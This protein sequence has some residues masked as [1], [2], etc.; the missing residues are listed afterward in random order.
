MKRNKHIFWLGALFFVFALIKYAFNTEQMPTAFIVFEILSFLV[1]LYIIYFVQNLIDVCKGGDGAAG[2]DKEC[3]K[4][5]AEIERLKLKLKRFEAQHQHDMESRQ[6]KGHE[7]V[8]TLQNRFHGFMEES[9]TK[10]VDELV[11]HYEVMAAVGYL[12][13]NDRYKV[14]KKFGIDDDVVLPDLTLDDGLH[15]QAL[16]DR[17]AMEITDI[18]EDYIEVSSAT[19][20]GQP[21][22]LYILPLL[23]GEHDGLVLEVAT[24]KKNDL[25]EV[26]NQFQSAQ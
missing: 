21:I 16:A 14:V 8:A 19:G 12:L 18:P 13:D 24:F 26:W 9:V 15:A 5:L 6:I 2:D 25:V 4:R 17:R 23:Q 20:S 10:L 7:L 3:V 1:L 22:Y 11:N